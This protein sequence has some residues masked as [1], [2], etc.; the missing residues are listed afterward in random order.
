LDYVRSVLDVAAAFGAAPY[1]DIDHMPRALAA[2][3]TPVRSDAEWPGA[4]GITWTNR[5][6]NVRPADPAVFASAVT[7]L[8]RRLVEGSGGKPGRPVRYLEFWNEPDLAYA[9]NPHVGDLN[10][11]FQT[12]GATLAA[13]DAY[14]KSTASSDGKAI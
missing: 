11:Y 12:A 13:L 14:R 7:G 4:C 5:V 1:L 3:Q 2:S 6:S 8:A 10:T 9:W